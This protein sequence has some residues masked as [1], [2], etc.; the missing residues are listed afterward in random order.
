MAVTAVGQIQGHALAS[1]GVPS[2]T[3]DLT[4]RNA[5]GLCVQ[6]DFGGEY[7]YL[8]G[9]G[10]TVAGDWVFYDEL[11][12]TTRAVASSV[13]GPMAIALA[14]VTLATNFGWYVIK[15]PAAIG[16]VLAAAGT[17]LDD[18]PPFITATAGQVDDES[19]GAGSTVYGAISRSTGTNAAPPTFQIVYPFNL[20]LA[21]V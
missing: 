19:S 5:L 20:G 7:I 12:A 18:T 15:H 4:Q 21:P 14:A 3:V 17:Y 11:W 8:S 6:D 2:A 1:V 9:I 13:G 10:S 16:N